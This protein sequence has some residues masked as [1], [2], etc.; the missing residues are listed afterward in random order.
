MTVL[1]SNR[2]L[3]YL[4]EAFPLYCNVLLVTMVLS[5]SMLRHYTTAI[6]LKEP[7]R[8]YVKSESSAAF[9]A[10][11]PKAPHR[12]HGDQLHLPSSKG[13]SVHA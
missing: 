9:A 7:W 10:E 4:E 6:D 1:D 11:K 2:D 5:S 13:Q 3:S 12:L 8:P